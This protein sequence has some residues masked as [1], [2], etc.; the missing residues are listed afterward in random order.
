ML[1]LLLHVILLQYMHMI[2]TLS[3]NTGGLIL[4]YF[5]QMLSM[6]QTSLLSLCYGYIATE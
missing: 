6:L 1:L 3:E 5:L 4:P 2:Y